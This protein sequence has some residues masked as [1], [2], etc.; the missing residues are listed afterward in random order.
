MASTLSL[1]DIQHLAD[2]IR[3][4]VRAGIPL[5]ACLADAGRGSGMRLQRLTQAISNELNHGHSLQEI[6]ERHSIGAPRMLAAAVGAGVCSGELALTVEMMGDFAADVL[7]LRNRL[8]HSAA[9]PLTIVAVAGVLVVLVIQHALEVFLDMIHSWNMTVHPWLLKILEWNREMPWW[10]LLLPLVGMALIAFWMI[11]GR[12][13]AMAFRGPERVLL[14]L[15]GVGA[16]V[17][18]LRS[19]TLSRML[20]LL[21]E[22]GLPMQDALTLAGGASGSARLDQACRHAAK[23]V[24]QGQPITSDSLSAAEKKNSLPALLS[25]CL[26]QVEYDESRMVHR[27]RSVAQFYRNRLERNATWVRLLMPVMMFIVIG[28]GCVL[29]YA[30]MVFWPVT[31]I[32]RN[33]GR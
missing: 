11:S 31:E 13:A 3:H 26:K 29:T 8:L 23:R 32:Y 33:L 17:R 24:Q 15:P 27:L 25:A 18:D 12:A 20:S 5:E 7:N 30:V 21:T 19:Y 10:T 9:Y 2:E 28:G 16:L 14:L 6:V 1:E 4:L 22:R